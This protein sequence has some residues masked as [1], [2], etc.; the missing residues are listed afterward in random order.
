VAPLSEALQDAR[1]QRMGQRF[2]DARLGGLPGATLSR[3]HRDHTG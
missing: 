1:A 2:R 3:L